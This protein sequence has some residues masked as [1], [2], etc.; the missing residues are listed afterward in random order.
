MLCLRSMCIHL[1]FYKERRCEKVQELPGGDLLK[2]SLY[3]AGMTR[4]SYLKRFSQ[5][6]MSMLEGCR[7]AQA[8]PFK[9]RCIYVWSV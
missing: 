6:L 3:H 2:M 9:N 7:N 5:E 1:K 4:S 8:P